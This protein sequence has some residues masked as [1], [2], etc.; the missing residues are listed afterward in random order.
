MAAK[1]LV[2]PSYAV[3]SGT[4]LFLKILLWVERTKLYYSLGAIVVALHLEAVR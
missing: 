4:L 3:T 1:I 2:W